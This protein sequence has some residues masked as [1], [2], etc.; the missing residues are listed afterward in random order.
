L[1]AVGGT[2]LGPLTGGWIAMN[3]NL[4]WRWIEWIE[5]MYV[6]TFITLQICL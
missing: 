2:G 5:M 3:P 6:A 4:E 1:A